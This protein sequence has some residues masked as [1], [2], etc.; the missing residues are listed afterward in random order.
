MGGWSSIKKQF[1]RSTNQVKK[2]VGRSADQVGK[3]IGRGSERLGKEFVREMEDVGHFVDDN[4]EIAALAALAA[5]TG[6]FGFAGAGLMGSGTAIQGGLSGLGSFLGVP[7]TGALGGTG[8]GLW[9]GGAAA[10]LAA[11][12]AAAGIGGGGLTSMG[13][14][15]GLTSFLGNAA[16]GALSKGAGGNALS[17]LFTGGSGNVIS[18]GLDLLGN[19]LGADAVKD[20]A[21]DAANIQ[22]E[23]LQKSL[24]YNNSVRDE[25]RG[26]NQ[27]SLS[28]GQNALDGFQN[29]DLTGRG[30]EIAAQM[31]GLDFD[32]YLK[33][34]S[35]DPIFKWKQQQQEQ[36]MNRQLASRGLYGSRA[37]LNAL[38]N[39]NMELMADEVDKMYGRATDAYN[40]DY[41]ALNDQFNFDQNLLNRDVGRY[42]D[43]MNNGRSG[44]NS[45]LNAGAGAASNNTNAFSN[46]GSALSNSAMNKANA[47]SNQWTGGANAI[48][49]GINNYNQY[50]QQLKDEAFRNNFLGVS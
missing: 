41:G 21:R 1:K 18:G 7:G 34:P 16:S 17:S 30:R 39:Q 40:R 22:R 35:D 9:S 43:L 8:T 13:L 23:M 3:E 33:D 32:S 19:Y 46:A 36:A 26:L 44:I 49:N 12:E 24:D 37:G 48:N 15:S 11:A 4:K 42:A 20:G 47:T 29:M 31:Q 6:G 45:I 25:A 5:V 14:S 38:G 2:Q 27:S 10:N 50:Q 28:A